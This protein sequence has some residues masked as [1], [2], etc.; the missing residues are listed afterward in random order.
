M[1]ATKVL[2]AQI[3]GFV[4]DT[5]AILGS[6]A[7]PLKVGLYRGNITPDGDTTV[8]DVDPVV[9]ASDV[10]LIS[11]P[12]A[13]HIDYMDAKTGAF[14]IKLV[15]PAGG[16]IFNTPDFVPNNGTI[17]GFFIINAVGAML[18][19]RNFDEPLEIEAGG[20]AI[21]LEEVTLEFLTGMFV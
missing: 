12:D 4:A 2:Q 14:K 16:W 3:A 7:A 5:E 17:R 1:P 11:V 15:E 6:V 20:G 8:D 13:P 9:D 10:I 21:N 19:C 18:Y